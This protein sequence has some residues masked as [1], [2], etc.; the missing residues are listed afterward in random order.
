MRLGLLFSGGKD[1]VYALARAS[2]H[3]EITCLV[4]LR[5]ENTESYMFHTPNIHITSLQAEALGIPL[6]E[7][8]TSGEKERELDDLAV[9]MGVARDR[10]GIGGIVTGAIESVYQSSRIQRICHKM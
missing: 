10:F 8:D 2:L 5:S 4:T 3:H 1:S 6:V 7:W 9:A